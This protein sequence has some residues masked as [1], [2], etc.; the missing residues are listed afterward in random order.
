M[1]VF[2]Q[3]LN[4]QMVLM[5]YILCGVLCRKLKIITADNQQ[6]FI[7]FVLSI[8][9]PCMVFNSFKNITI[10]VLKQSLYVLII[11]LVICSAATI[12]GK[13][14]YR[15]YSEDKRNVLRYATLIN[16][17][18]F[19]GLP[20]AENT[21]GSQ[22]LIY[23]SIFLIPIRIFMWSAGVTILSNEKV[24]KKQLFFKLMKNPNIVAVYLGIARGLLHLQL[25]KFIDTAIV[26]MSSCV[27]PISM[28][29]IGAII[30]D[31]NINTLFEKDVLLYSGLRLIVL[32]FL[33]F[34]VTSLLGLSTIIIGT[35]MLLT[36]MPAGT[37]TALLAAQ[38]N[39]NVEFASKL[40]FVTTALSLITVPFLMLLL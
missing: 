24:D 32:P 20:L 4:I 22:G 26:N 6:K 7:N 13:F 36:S 5:I 23:A 30:S 29:I 33:V 11:S 31:V 18:G 19:A 40:V 25:P 16:N 8:L 17:A 9:M 1:N 12:I 34:L 21:F 37:T 27:S 2:L 10:D 14:L 39:A 28:I 35:S 15:N 3:M 38:Y